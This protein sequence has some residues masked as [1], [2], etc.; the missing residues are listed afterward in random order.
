MDT[1]ILPTWLMTS[2]LI[3]FMPTMNVKT[4]VEE[5]N[6]SPRKSDCGHSK[7]LFFCRVSPISARIFCYI[8][9]FNARGSGYLNL[10]FHNLSPI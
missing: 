9:P 2:P 1:A 10:K 3:G 5:L 4:K 6:F 7:I 8:T